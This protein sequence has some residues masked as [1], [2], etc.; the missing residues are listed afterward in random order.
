M[1][2]YFVDKARINC[3]Y[4]YISQSFCTYSAVYCS[5]IDTSVI[6]VVVLPKKMRYNTINSHRRITAQNQRQAQ[7]RFR[8][9]INAK[10]RLVP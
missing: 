8:E 3:I 1:T 4:Y 2:I 5:Y 6:F 7:G 9:M 10:R